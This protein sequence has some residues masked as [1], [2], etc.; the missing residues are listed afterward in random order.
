MC[1]P[2][3]TQSWVNSFKHKLS[4]SASGIIISKQKTWPPHCYKCQLH[5]MTNGLVG[6]SKECTTRIGIYCTNTS[7]CFQYFQCTRIGIYFQWPTICHR[8][9]SVHLRVL[10]Q[11][12]SMCLIPFVV[13][14]KFAYLSLYQ[15]VFLSKPVF[16]T[17]W[18][19]F[20]LKYFL[21]LGYFRRRNILHA[22]IL[23]QVYSR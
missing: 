18:E 12:Q 15:M 21:T 13:T 6:Q 19:N 8:A 17:Y 3:Q 9:S 4:S 20:V 1:A 16:S 11:L 2:L 7:M 10:L 5:P 22:P 14:A 23:K